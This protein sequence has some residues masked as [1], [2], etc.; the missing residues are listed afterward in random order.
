MNPQYIIYHDLIGFELSAKSK[1]KSFRS[2]FFDIGTVIDESRDILITHKDN[3]IKKFIKKDYIFRILIPISTKNE[4]SR[5][6]EVDGNKIIGLPE[7]R[8]RSLRKKKR[9]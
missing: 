4:N 6:L 7:N 3:K 2:N 8:L 9:L 1:F 5:I